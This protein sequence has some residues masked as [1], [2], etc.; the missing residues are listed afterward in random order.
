MRTPDLNAASAGNAAYSGR[1]ESSGPRPVGANSRGP[2][3][4]AD[5]GA[6]HSGAPGSG[7]GY[8]TQAAGRAYGAA[9]SSMRHRGERKRSGTVGSVL[10]LDLGLGSPRMARGGSHLEPATA[11]VYDSGDHVDR[12]RAVERIKGLTSSAWDEPY[13][14]EERKVAVRPR[15]SWEDACDCC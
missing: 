12:N 8:G 4:L 11:L 7:F 3:Y 10:S 6:S 2:S 13:D 15:S 1:Y 9:A 5:A 14:E